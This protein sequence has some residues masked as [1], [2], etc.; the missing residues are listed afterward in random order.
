MET[1]S[2]MGSARRWAYGWRVLLAGFLMVAGPLSGA[3]SSSREYDVKAVFLFNFIQ[4]TEWPTNAF[5][6]TNAPIVIGVFGKDPFGSALENTVKGEVINGRGLKVQHFNRL[7][8][9][10]DCHLLF[11]SS[12][13]AS[14]SLQIVEA[15]RGKPILTVGET[16]G[17]VISGGCVR[18]VTENNKIRLRIN[19]ESVKRANLTISA[20]LLRLAEIVAPEKD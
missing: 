8:E 19:L 4:F 10:K 6:A 11:V 13:E 9:V 16:D 5:A 12:S 15:L 7:D 14:R 18:F 1:R 17:F 3:Q 20:K 2:Q